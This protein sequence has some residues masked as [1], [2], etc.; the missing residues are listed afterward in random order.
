MAR[1]RTD[2]TL[3]ALARRRVDLSSAHFG[4]AF[5]MLEAGGGVA[6]PSEACELEPSCPASRAQAG[7]ARRRASRL[8]VAVPKRQLKRAVDRNAL[9]RVAR[10]AWRL[11]PW[12]E[13]ARP[14]VLMLKLR[15]AEAEWKTTGRSALKKAWRAEIDELFSR[16][17]RRVDAQRLPDDAAGAANSAVIQ[18]QPSK[19]ASPEP[20]DA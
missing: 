14:Q 10:E 2:A 9:K 19:S 17:R 16:L 3:A 6:T 11:A 13:R 5:Q 12:G 20:R 4:L 7:A 18:P 15:R 8:A 1:Q